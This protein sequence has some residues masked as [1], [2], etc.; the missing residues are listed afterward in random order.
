M[1]KCFDIAQMV[2]NQASKEFCDKFQQDETKLTDLENKC[3]IIDAFLEP[4]GSFWCNESYGVDVDVDIDTQEIIIGCDFDFCEFRQ[5]DPMYTL[6][7]KAN[8]IIIN[9]STEHE[10][11]IRMEM[12]F[13]GIWSRVDNE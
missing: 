3:Y 9:M 4:G 7:E 1:I 6:M 12:R 8:R 11:A 13:P 2:I 5:K 10:G